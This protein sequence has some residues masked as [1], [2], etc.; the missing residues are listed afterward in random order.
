VEGAIEF[1]PVYAG[2]VPEEMRARVLLW[3]WWI[4][5]GDRWVDPGG[6]SNP[7]LLWT[8]DDAN[9]HVFDH[10]LAFIPES[11]AGFRHRHIFRE[12][13]DYWTLDYRANLLDEMRKAL[14]GFDVAWAS[15]PAEWVAGVVGNSRE[16]LFEILWRFEA[17]LVKFWNLS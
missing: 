15:M 4:S 1:R 5:N 14:E 10:N 8:P 11:R 17:D 13:Q 9:L 12:S 7:N 16:N 3:D 2:Q 6:R